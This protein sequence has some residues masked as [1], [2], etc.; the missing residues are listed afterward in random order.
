MKNKLLFACF[1]LLVSHFAQAKVISNTEYGFT[2]ENESIIKHSPEKAWQWF[3]SD[4]D[5]WW[6]KS[7]SWW[8]EKGTFT[9]D[10]YAGGCFCEKTDAKTG[11]SAEHMRVNFVDK[12]KL[13]RMTGGLGP[14]QGM[15][16]YGALDWRFEQ[17]EQG[18]TK[19]TLR[20]QANG[21]NPE[22][23][24]ELIPIVDKVQAMQL[25]ALVEYANKQVMQQ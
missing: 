1:S 3:I 24:K 17:T 15:G 22:S 9:L 8:G 25:G 16:I 6:P 5:Q 20:Y 14:L 19:V 2:I 21:Y 12:H 23:F 13:L 10:D 11:N 7:H 18:D 4:I